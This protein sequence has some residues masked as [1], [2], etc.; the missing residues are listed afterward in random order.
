M[1]SLKPILDSSS[2]P[3]AKIIKALLSGRSHFTAFELVS[4]FTEALSTSDTVTGSVPKRSNTDVHKTVC[5]C[6]VWT[7]LNRTSEGIMIRSEMLSSD[8]FL[9]AIIHSVIVT[10]DLQ[11]IWQEVLSLIFLPVRCRITKDNL[12]LGRTGH[13]HIY[14][15]LRDSLRPVW[16]SLK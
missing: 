16:W 12:R 4:Q 15:F 13:K 3:M 7:A 9:N 11:N 2:C 10:I 5:N 14:V 6:L 8:F 1:T